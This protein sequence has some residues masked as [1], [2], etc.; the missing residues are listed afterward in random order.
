MLV[1]HSAAF[2]FCLSKI[3]SLIKWLLNTVLIQSEYPMFCIL[4]S[5]R[6]CSDV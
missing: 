5:F 4:N 2:S 3:R 6:S 1:V